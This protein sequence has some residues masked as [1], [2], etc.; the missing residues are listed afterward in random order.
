VWEGGADVL[1]LDHVEELYDVDL[2]VAWEELGLFRK[3]AL[4]VANTVLKPG[5][6]RCRKFVREHRESARGDQG[7]DRSR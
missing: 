1:F 4:V 2:K 3:V 6:P 7:L 5:A